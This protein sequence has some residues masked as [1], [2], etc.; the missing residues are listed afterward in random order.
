MKLKS[1]SSSSSTSNLNSFHAK[2]EAQF[3]FKNDP[4]QSLSTNL[5]NKNGEQQT[6]VVDIQQDSS[7]VSP[8]V[9]S[10]SVELNNER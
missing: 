7:E 9:F 2:K 10:S 6:S 8:D 3:C 1:N 4:D 5:D